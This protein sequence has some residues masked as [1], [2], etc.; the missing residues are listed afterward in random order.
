[1][2]GKTRYVYLKKS[3]DKHPNLEPEHEYTYDLTYSENHPISYE[4]IYKHIIVPKKYE[5]DGA[6][7]IKI[8]PDFKNPKN[9]YGKF[10]IV[11]GKQIV[12]TFFAQEGSA[13]LTSASLAHG[14]E[15][16][17]GVNVIKNS[18]NLTM[19]DMKDHSMIIKWKKIDA[20]HIHL[21]VD[22]IEDKE[23]SLWTT[24]WSMLTT[25]PHEDEVVNLASYKLGGFLS[26]FTYISP[27]EEIHIK[28]EFTAQLKN[29]KFLP[30]DLVKPEPDAEYSDDSAF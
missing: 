28:T 13:Q 12:L 17:E 30:F 16:Q 3:D 2:L 21:Y 10:Y 15:F 5:F 23:K 24:T 7:K 25:S 27:I 22:A 9:T 8:N 14:G 6:F 26:G 11:L 20:Y 18:D 4:P 1:M 29:T 19:G